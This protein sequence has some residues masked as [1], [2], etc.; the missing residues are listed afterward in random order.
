VARFVA[1]LDAVWLWIESETSPTSVVVLQ[2]FR[3]PA[4]SGPEW[5]DDLYAQITDPTHVKPGFRRR[6]YKSAAT[7]GQF[8]WADDGLL[9]MPAHVR[10]ATLPAP[11]RIR[12]LLE[13]VGE[14]HGQVMTRERPQ[15]EA[16]LV[17]G[18]EDGRFA[19]LTKLHHSMFDGVNMGRHMLS[20]LSSDP[21][22]TDC[23]A[24][25]IVPN[26]PPAV[27]LEEPGGDGGPVALAKQVFSSAGEVLGSL[28]TLVKTVPATVREREVPFAA[29]DSVLNGRVGTS[30]RFAG[31]A[32]PIARLKAV[33]KS[34]GASINDVGLAMCGAA[35][36]AYL[37]E[38]DALPASS[39]VAGVPVS[40]SG[41]DA[42]A[43]SRDGNAIGAVLCNLGTDLDDPIERLRR[44][45]ASM[46]NNKSMM[47]GLDPLTTTAVTS[48]NMA[49]FLLGA[50]PGLPKL[51]R[52]AFNL[53]VSNVP[54]L[55]KPLYW[56]GAEMTDY[57]PSSVVMNGQALNI[58]LLSYKDDIAIG[59]TADPEVLP[60][61]Q[62][63]LV[64]LENA[65]TDLEKASA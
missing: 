32:W 65:L 3:P 7:G 1:P 46:T 64:H 19:L 53:V 31:D 10:R 4:G 48:G 9:D 20:G 37:I 58:T 55:R 8:A 52:P 61:M 30:R 57:Y 18:L 47:A 26:K 35:L 59:L 45:H 63:L 51:P 2:I 60:H 28:K 38:R 17:D 56:N 25:W 15:W 29:P 39:L 5:L 11:G 16:R 27:Q 54:G 13:F 34:T 44:V 50:V 42:G 40:L 33:A 23:V 22:A 49:G 12:E 41:T 62:R 14:L 36:R 21:K 6:A 24:P 43:A